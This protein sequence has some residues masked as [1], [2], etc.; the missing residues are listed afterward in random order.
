MFCFINDNS[1]NRLWLVISLCAIVACCGEAKAQQANLEKSKAFEF[2]GQ[3]I[4]K[5]DSGFELQTKD[6]TA[7]RIAVGESTDYA[8]RLASPWFSRSER[9]V[10]VDGKKQNDGTRERIN[11]TLPEGQL[12]L[13]VQ[14]RSISQ[15]DRIMKQPTWRLN[16]YLISDQ[17]IESAM[18]TGKSLLLAGKLDLE[19]SRLVVDDTS[20][21]ITLGHRAA[22]L[23]G[24]SFADIVAWDTVV[25]V[26]GNETGGLNSAD[27]VLFMIR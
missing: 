16:N 7:I 26:T 8:M 24:R 27:T 6:G 1:K 3:V 9:K 18:P 2:S 13:L 22:T 19:K 12:Y 4:S 11:Y 15:R 21:S 5:S 23:R 10:V 17:P 14:F 20:R 25:L